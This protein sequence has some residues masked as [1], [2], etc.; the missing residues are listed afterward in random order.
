MPRLDGLAV[1]SALRDVAPHT[2]V[3]I[4]SLY[5]G[6]ERAAAAGAGAFVE[7]QAADPQLI[8]AIRQLAG[9]VTG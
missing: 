1:T 6:A 2:A 7:K 4:L 9:T 3:V 5:G 8:T